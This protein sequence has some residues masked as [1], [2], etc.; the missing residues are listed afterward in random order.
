MKDKIGQDQDSISIMN[1]QRKQDKIFKKFL[2][3]FKIN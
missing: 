3:K 1:A 2:K